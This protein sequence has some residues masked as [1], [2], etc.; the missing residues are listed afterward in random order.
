MKST[1]I[2]R[3]LKR[4]K[5]ALA[6]LTV[7]TASLSAGPIIIDGTDANDHGSASG[8]VNLSGWL[9]M[10]RA[11]ESLASQCT[12]C[13][14]VVRVL[15]V[16]A[17]GTQ[18]RNAL[19]SAFTKSS[20]PAAGWT[21]VYTA[22]ADIAATLA[23][24]SP[25][26]TGILHIPT[27]ENAGGDLSTNALITINGQGAAI[28]SFVN[29]GG[30]LW[31]MAESP[32][33]NVPAFGWLTSVIPGIV[34]A[35]LGGGGTSSNITL[36]PDGMG[37]FPG[38]T[39]G[40]LAGAQPWH[41]Y[42]TGN[43]GSLKILATAPDGGTT[44]NIILGGGAGTTLDSGQT[45]YQI[46]YSSNLNLGDS[47]INITNSGARGA[48]LAAGTSASTTGAIC[49]NVYAF[50]PDEQMISCCSCPVT[51]NGLVSLSAR[52]DLISNTLTPAQP[53]SIIVK[54]LASA[55]VGGSCTGSAAS[56]GELTTGLHAW[57]TTVHAGATAA[58]A[59]A[60][61][62]SPFLPAK[63]SGVGTPGTGELYRLTQ[64]CTF[65]NANGSGFG[66]CRSCRLGG[67]GSGRL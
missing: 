35:D 22:E 60:V 53:T 37:A 62:E 63:L 67:L 55:P 7:L 43:L 9:Y 23:S 24:L 29:A 38:L 4:S 61:T 33:G 16:T 45:P 51:P 40:D 52:Q 5:L 48:G 25:G 15:G 13:A 64:L 54:L 20:L 3:L 65:I 44:R 18:A 36:T 12:G 30:G 66:I 59:L 26:T 28:A 41:N 21:I 57:G 49:V 42:F 58:T 19:D 10:Q 27:V 46:R 17:T 6:I 50:S 34:I 47:V 11:L 39:N 8:G 32:A 56:P 31:A 1:I 2:S 14:K